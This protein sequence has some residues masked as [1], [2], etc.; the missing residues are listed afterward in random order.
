MKRIPIDNSV[1]RYLRLHRSYAWT[2][3][4]VMELRSSNASYRPDMP[5]L[6]E[7]SWERKVAVAFMTFSLVLMCGAVVVYEVRSMIE[8]FTEQMEIP[9]TAGGGWR[10]LPPDSAPTVVHPPPYAPPSDP[11]VRRPFQC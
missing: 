10:L 6:D 9:R 3:I 7:W 8:P 4:M 1:H 5:D 2:C 11:T